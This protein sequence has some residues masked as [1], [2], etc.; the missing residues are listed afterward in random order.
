MTEVQL[1]TNKD[2]RVHSLFLDPSGRHCIISLRSRDNLYL[3][4]ASKKGVRHL[5]KAKGHLIEVVA[6]NRAN[7]SDTSTGEILLG[8]SDGAIYETVIQS[9]D[10]GRFFS[11][12]AD[13]YFRQV[14]KVS[15]RLTGLELDEIRYASG[16]GGSSSSG[17]SL[18]RFFVIATT[19]TRLYQF[20]GGVPQNAEP[21]IFQHLFEPYSN[22][23]GGEP[24]F[25]EIPEAA[26]RTTGTVSHLSLYR[27]QFR[28]RPTALAWLVGRG[29]Y[30]GRIDT[31]DV[32]S[33]SS[34]GLLQDPN[35]IP[36]PEARQKEPQQVAL[37]VELTE[38]HLILLYA[39]CLK[40]V[41]VLNETCVFV[42]KLGALPQLGSERLLG[43]STDTV[44]GGLLWSYTDYSVY[45]HRLINEA[46]HVWR[47][48]LQ[49]GDFEAALRYCGEN[50]LHKDQVCGFV[51]DCTMYMCLLRFLLIVR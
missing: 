13:S 45:K 47:I 12:T 17:S 38:F 16:V 25:K 42:E 26:P 20:S 15:D 41:C 24:Q 30:Y 14:F 32:S 40:L 33:I 35:L 22:L 29:V 5:T 43:L 18:Q 1:T 50:A 10:E 51:R 34:R 27:P 21:P 28:S 11:A 48:Y 9:Q 7:T 23:P 6:W 46:R 4:R 37:G 31:S 2:D 44:A 3:S 8:T 19:P 36:Y 39:D 49:R